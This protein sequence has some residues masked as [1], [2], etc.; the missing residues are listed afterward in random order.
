MSLSD[1]S[2]ISRTI[3][4]NPLRLVLIP[5]FVV[6]IVGTVGLVGYLSLRK[7]FSRYNRS[8]TDDRKYGLTTTER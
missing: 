4:K 1:G 5:S 2:H 7:C 6:Q 8:P 3:A